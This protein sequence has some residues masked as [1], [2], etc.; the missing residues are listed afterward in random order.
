MITT[1]L[2]DEFRF[3]TFRRLSPAIHTHWRAYLAFGLFFTWLAGVGRYWDNP[4]AELWQHLG[5]GSIVYVFVLALML[6]PLRP[7]NWTY[8]TV[9]LFVTLTAPPAVLYA[10]PVE[11]FVSPDAARTL[12]AWFLAIVAAWR[13]GLYTVFLRR[14][15]ALAPIAVFVATLLPLV[16][17]VVALAVLNLEHVVFDLMGGMRD[18]SRSPNDAAYS[19]VIILSFFSIYSAPFLLIGY[20]ALIFAA[21]HTAKEAKSAEVPKPENAK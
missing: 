10:I 15:A 12:N 21:R 16:I 8:Q 1:I 7:R 3:L 9:L 14:V 4:R 6:A 13:V 11:K 17:I 18:E 2:A 5:L 20:V 19:V